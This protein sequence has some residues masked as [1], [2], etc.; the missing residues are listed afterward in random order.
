LDLLSKNFNQNCPFH[1]E[2]QVVD[3]YD[4]NGTTYKTEQY[5]ENRPYKYRQIKSTLN[6]EILNKCI[7]I[8]DETFIFDSKIIKLEIE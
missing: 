3:G 6:K 8:F 2:R 5:I 4:E 1:L 7:Q